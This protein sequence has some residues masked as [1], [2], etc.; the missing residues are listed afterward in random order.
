MNLKKLFRFR[1]SVYL[2]YRKASKYLLWLWILINKSIRKRKPYRVKLVAIAKNEACYLPEWLAHHQYFGFDHIS[3]YVNNTTDNTSNIVRK[4]SS[5]KHIEFCDGDEYF[6]P[7]I[8][9]P[10]T[11]VYKHELNRS[12]KQGYSHVMFLD[13][14]EFWTPKDLKTTIHDFLKQKTTDVVCFEWLNRT[15]ENHPFLPSID[16]KIVGIKGNH[17]KSL[18]STNV[19]VEDVNPHSILGYKIKHQ[20]ADGSIYHVDKN[21]F[22]KISREEV[23]SPLKEIF[24][25]HRMFRSQEEYVALLLRGRPIQ[26]R[27][28]ADVFKTNRSG[29]IPRTSKVSISFESEVL[30]DYQWFLENFFANYKLHEEIMLGREFVMGKREQVSRVILDSPP[31]VFPILSKIF[32]RVTLPDVVAAME[33]KK[34]KCELND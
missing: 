28:Y 16:K 10:Q 14:D 13:I 22:A 21:N 34:S 24:I 7:D 20:L 17:V 29:Y 5:V 9:V 32:T 4:L 30:I 11:Q 27:P 3:V 31:E 25:L 1:F 18:V 6:Q 12:K 33:T 8:N 23:K 2:S 19:L 15:N 26:N